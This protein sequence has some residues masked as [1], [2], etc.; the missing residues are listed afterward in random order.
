MGP[1]VGPG[2]GLVCSGG[3]GVDV[4]GSERGLSPMEGSGDGV[5]LWASVA[6]PTIADG[7]RLPQATR[8]SNSKN[9]V[10]TDPRF[11]VSSPFADRR[12]EASG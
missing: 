9:N 11:T 8:V 1:V 2:S 12:C 4:G 5:L 10:L 6:E 3:A 7:S